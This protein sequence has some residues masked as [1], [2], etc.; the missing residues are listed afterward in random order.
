MTRSR[1]RSAHGASHG[2]RGERRQRD[3]RGAPQAAGPRWLRPV[4][5]TRWRRIVTY[6]ITVACAAVTGVLLV[7]HSSGSAPPRARQYLAFNACLLTGSRG[8]AG[9]QAAQAWAGMQDASLA[10]RAKVEY[11]SA[12]A[13]RRP[14]PPCRSWRAWCSATAT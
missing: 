9:P 8:L 14:R 5:G 4:M 6:T 12:M 11:L 1:S 7:A 10:T 2:R 3:R 13:R